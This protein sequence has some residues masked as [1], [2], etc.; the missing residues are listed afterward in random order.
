MTHYW[1]NAATVL[2]VA[3]CQV[4]GSFLTLT[5]NTAHHQHLQ[6]AIA[7]CL[8]LL[9][10]GTSARA[11]LAADWLAAWIPYTDFQPITLL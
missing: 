1:Q 8:T 9:L 11:W 2:L 3:I 4:T 6:C 5:H 10:N 7:A